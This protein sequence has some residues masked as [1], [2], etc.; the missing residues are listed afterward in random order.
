MYLDDCI[1]HGRGPDQFCQ[2]LRDV[3]E[4][5]KKLNIFLKPKKCKF[6]MAMVEYCGNEISEE[7]LSMSKKKI[8]KVLDF[9]KPQTA[10]QMKQ[11]VGLLN[12]FRDYCQHHSQI[13]KPLHDMIL[14]YQKKTRGTNDIRQAY[15]RF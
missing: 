11:L 14:N 3:L 10:G 15:C 2:R 4:R 13:M 6:G 9:P 5:F 1:V 12:Y 8:Q 7:G